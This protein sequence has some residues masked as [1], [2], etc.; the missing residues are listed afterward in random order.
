MYKFEIGKEIGREEGAKLTLFSQVCKK[1]I[2]E[3]SEA[4]IADEL[5]EDLGLI[6]QICRT[7][8]DFA[9]DY[10]YEDIYKEWRNQFCSAEQ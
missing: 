3:K 10:P 1:L 5:E 4:E 8:R 9:P 2:K 7:A 6:Q